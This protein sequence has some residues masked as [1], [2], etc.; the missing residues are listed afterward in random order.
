MNQTTKRTLISLMLVAFLLAACAPAPAATQNP[1]ELQQLIQQSVEMA[2]TTQNAQATEL[3]MTVI[4]QNTPTATLPAVSVPSDTPFPTAT[5]ESEFVQEEIA[6][7]TPAPTS[8]DIPVTPGR[9]TRCESRKPTQ[10]KVGGKA[11]VV[12]RVNFRTAPGL[13]KRKILTIEPNTQVEV[14]NGPVIH[15]LG[16]QRYYYWWQIKLPDGRIGWSVELSVCGGYY[17][18]EPVN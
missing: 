5:T 11:T 10:L 4:A 8:T 15:K 9:S 3:A 12:Q 1:A 17:F 14:L 2:F 7:D 16:Y 13:L 18:M 6:T